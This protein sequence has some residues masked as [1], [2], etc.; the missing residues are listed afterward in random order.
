MKLKRISTAF[1]AFF[2]LSLFVLESSFAF[3]SQLPAP[4][5]F[6]FLTSPYTYDSANQL[7]KSSNKT[8]SYDANG[9]LIQ[10]KTLSTGVIRSYVYDYEN[11]PK[12]V[13]TG[14]VQTASYLYDGLGRRT[15]SAIGTQALRTYYDGFETLFEANNQ[16]DAITESYVHGPRID[17]IL[18]SSSGAYLH[19]GL[20][21]VSILGVSC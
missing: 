10:E 6:S 5:H 2:Y 15:V 11:R 1:L 19:D 20:G 16:T 14:S 18:Q 3:S 7:L 9:N 8:Y 17:E 12:T 4:S 13:K 21:S